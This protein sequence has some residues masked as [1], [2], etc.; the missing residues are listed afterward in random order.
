MPEIGDTDKKSRKRCPKC[1]STK[2]KQRE[3]LKKPIRDS[4]EGVGG[5][6]KKVWF[7]GECGEKFE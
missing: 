5:V 2:V 4:F 1:N 3:D 6:Y 7:C